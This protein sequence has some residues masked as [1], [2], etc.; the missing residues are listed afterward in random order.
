[1]YT[2]IGPFILALLPLC[3]HAWS[4]DV[5]IGGYVP[6]GGYDAIE[7]PG[8]ELI[9]AIADTVAGDGMQIIFRSST[10]GGLNWSLASYQVT[11]NAVTTRI[12]LLKSQTTVYCLYLAGNTVR[13]Y[14]MTTGVTGEYLDYQAEE[15]DAVMTPT[16]WLYL[17]I[18]LPG[19]DDIRRAG[20][21]DGGVTWAGD[22]ASVT[23]LGAVPRV[24]I[25]PG[26]TIILNYYGPVLADR[27]KSKI[28]A[29]FYNELAPGDL[30]I[31]PGSFQD[32]VM[33]ETVDKWRFGSAI[34]NGRVWFF[35]EQG[36]VGQR[37]LQ[38]RISIDNGV[39]Y[40]SPF[41]VAGGGGED[42]AGFDALAWA[43]PSGARVELVY[44]RYTTPGGV[45]PVLDPLVHTFASAATPGTFA[46]GAVVSEHA[47]GLFTTGS[48]PSI[49]GTASGPGV[50]WAGY[51][52]SAYEL[53]WDA[54][55]FLTS[56]GPD[57]DATQTWSLA[58]NPAHDE[59]TITLP[60]EHVRSFIV[61]DTRGRT[62]HLDPQRVAPGVY[63]LH[64][65]HMAPGIYTIAPAGGSATTM[66]LRFMVAR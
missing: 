10:D 2:S 62:T 63:R 37:T 6:H 5:P 55:H 65:G 18:Q 30:N 21:N 16:G 24:S 34:R 42:V 33:D 8:G 49:V 40:G 11:G 35:W 41:Q 22:S 64:V 7:A 19:T 39:S 47:P 60:D 26:D 9:A 28:R 53:Y 38:C 51:A 12:K 23:G 31:S 20:S 13:V 48:A 44:A 52:G 56:T 58:P 32:I 59:L 36:T 66:P 3:G 1:M 25:S 45:D 46:T 29:A 50:A 27:P 61:V 14:N 15:F 4:P 57:T 54:E 43:H 17:W